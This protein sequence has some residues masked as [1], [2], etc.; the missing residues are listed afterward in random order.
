MIFSRRSGWLKNNSA[1]RGN[2][3]RTF[4]T[5]RRVV[6][7]P[8]TSRPSQR[9]AA[10]PR[11]TAVSTAACVSRPGVGMATNKLPGDTRRQ[12][13]ATPFTSRE[14]GPSPRN[15]RIKLANSSS[16]ISIQRFRRIQRQIFWRRLRRLFFHRDREVTSRAFGDISENWNGDFGAVITFLRI[17]REE[18]LLRRRSRHS[19]FP[20]YRRTRGSLPRDSDGKTTAADGAKRFGVECDENAELI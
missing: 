11:S 17:G 12:S 4:A 15:G 13:H 7:I 1:T 3:A 14:S 10:A 2:V 5:C 6:R 20:K 8:T 19:S 16:L 18:R 9:I